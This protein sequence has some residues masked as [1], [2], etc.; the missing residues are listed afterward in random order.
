MKQIQL[1][2]EFY[3]L[4]RFQRWI[5]LYKKLL[6]ASS[7]QQNLYLEIWESHKKNLLIDLKIW[8]EIL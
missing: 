1:K 6:I 2:F 5:D 7:S 4:G 3:V 8:I